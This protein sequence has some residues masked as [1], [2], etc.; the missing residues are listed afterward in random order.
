MIRALLLTQAAILLAVSLPAP[1]AVAASQDECAIWL[2]LPTGF[3]AGCSDAK[4]A[5][6]RRILKGKSPLP[7]WGSCAVTYASTPEFTFAVGYETYEPCRDGFLLQSVEELSV[8]FC[9]SIEPTESDEGEPR[10]ETYPATTRT[11]RRYLQ[12][13]ENGSPIRVL[14]SDGNVVSD[15]R[16][17][18]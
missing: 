10:F 18:Y 13:F 12:L 7:A 1:P 6:E 5:F 8:A 3:L 11:V 2:C 17:F 9:R 4:K 16:F 14:D 15:G